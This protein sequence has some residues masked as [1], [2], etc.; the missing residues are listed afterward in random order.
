MEN[1]IKQLQKTRNLNTKT[2]SRLN[3]EWKRLINKKYQ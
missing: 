3:T 2:K 1:S